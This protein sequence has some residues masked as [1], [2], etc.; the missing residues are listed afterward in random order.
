V[1]AG[2]YVA[3]GDAFAEQGRW[4]EGQAA[5]EMAMKLAPKAR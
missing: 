2:D 3:A 4:S 1:D 5:F